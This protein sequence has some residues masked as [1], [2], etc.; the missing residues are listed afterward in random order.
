MID[1]D[2]GR[3]QLA[4]APR[5]NKGGIE[6]ARKIMMRC[7]PGILIT[8]QSL[9]LQSLSV[10][11]KRLSKTPFCEAMECT[12]VTALTFCSQN[13]NTTEA[14][15]KKGLTSQE[16]GFTNRKCAVVLCCARLSYVED[17]KGFFLWLG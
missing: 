1:K 16:G 14:L 3:W 6:G 7:S 10:D 2:T 12:D 9:F 8:S 13:E 4:A 17:L 5:E 11:S 15:Q